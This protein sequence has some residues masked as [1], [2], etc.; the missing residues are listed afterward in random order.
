MA[1]LKVAYKRTTQLDGDDL[2]RTG[3]YAKGVAAGSALTMNEQ[4][5]AGYVILL[6]TAAG[7]TVTLP[8]SRGEGAV[9]RFVVHALATSNSHIIKVAN[10]SDA[11]QGIIHTGDD[12]GA[13]EQWFAATAG[14]SDTITLNRTTTGSVTV[15]EYIEIVDIAPNKFQVIGFITNTGSAETP[16]SAGV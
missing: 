5:H 9:Y 11:F 4:Q 3:G 8:A 14:T 2:S 10:A 12:T 1:N 16:F 6:D 15:G 13:N 7:S